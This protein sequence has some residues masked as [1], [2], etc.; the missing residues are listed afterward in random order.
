MCF[1]REEMGLILIVLL[2]VCDVFT[3]VE[4]EILNV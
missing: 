2:S 1:S 4:H 3:P